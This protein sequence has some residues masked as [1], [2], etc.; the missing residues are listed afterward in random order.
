MFKEVKDLTDVII[1][2]TN[3][4]NGFPKEIKIVKATLV[5]DDWGTHFLDIQYE[6]DGIVYDYLKQ[7][8]SNLSGAVNE[9]L[10]DIKD[11]YVRFHEVR[12]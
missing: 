9:A 6:E 11:F 4:L 1:K 7:I 8:H 5:V 3:E 10:G 2:M 12:Q